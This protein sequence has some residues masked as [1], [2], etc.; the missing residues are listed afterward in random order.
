MTMVAQWVERLKKA[1]KGWGT[2]ED[3]VFAVLTEALGHMQEVISAFPD[4]EDELHGELTEKELKRALPLF[5][6]V[7]PPRL[8]NPEGVDD[9]QW[10]SRLNKAFHPSGLFNGTD[11][12]EV[13][14]VLREANNVMQMGA[15]TQL[16]DLNYTDDGLEE[17]LYSELSGEDLKTA[18]R[19]YY[20]G[21]KKTP[22]P[23]TT[24]PPSQPATE[25]V[26]LPPRLPLTLVDVTLVPGPSVQELM[27]EV[28]TERAK[29]GLYPLNR[30]ITKLSGNIYQWPQNFF[31]QQLTEP[32]L[33]TQMQN[34]QRIIELHDRAYKKDPKDIRDFIVDPLMKDI[35]N[36]IVDWLPLV[37][38][39]VK[40]DLKDGIRDGLKSGMFSLIE[41]AIDNAEKMDDKTKK[42][43]K[44][45]AKAGLSLKF[46]SGPP[47]LNSDS[48]DNAPVGGGSASSL[49]GPP[50][51]DDSHTG[52]EEGKPYTAPGEKI[53]DSPSVPLP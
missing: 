42:A 29:I 36:P 31:N 40:P 10:A 2:D 26:Q 28:D 46:P 4:L 11:E 38:D 25:T 27:D 15:L 47:S 18:M 16:Y 33:W 20:T 44:E 53:I 14:L 41:T 5:Y 1:F 24:P 6:E 35:F 34:M 49:E 50:A 22:L 9:P 8:I 51:P 52:P 12:D 48:S 17:E 7:P 13:M 3:E 23:E 39:S 32:D 21:F 45:A 43:L 30:D 37:P 19:L